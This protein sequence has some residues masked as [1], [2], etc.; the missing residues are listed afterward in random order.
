MTPLP[1]KCDSAAPSTQTDS[2]STPLTCGLALGLAFA[3][4]MQKNDGVPVLS[5]AARGRAPRPSLATPVPPVSTAQGKDGWGG[6]KAE[7]LTVRLDQRLWKRRVPV[8]SHARV[9]ALGWDFRI[10]RVC[11]Q[12]TSFPGGVGKWVDLAALAVT[13]RCAS[14]G[15]V[16]SFCPSE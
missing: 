4:K 1:L 15:S 6:W 14:S 9:R 13:S 12:R 16:V 8:P 3:D 5:L 10:C 11:I 7:A 2:A